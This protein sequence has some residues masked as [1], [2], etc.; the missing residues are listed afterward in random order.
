MRR[1]DAIFRFLR[2]VVPVPVGVME[3]PW[4]RSLSVM[5]GFLFLFSFVLLFFVSDLL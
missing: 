2:D 1:F 5:A 4:V 3:V